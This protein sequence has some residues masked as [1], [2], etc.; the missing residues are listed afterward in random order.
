MVIELT[1]LIEFFTIHDIELYF[2]C[3]RMSKPSSEELS[4]KLKIEI[5]K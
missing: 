1:I 3:C 5:T 2:N 4:A